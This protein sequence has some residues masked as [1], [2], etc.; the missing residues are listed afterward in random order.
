MKEIKEISVLKEKYGSEF[1]LSDEKNKEHNFH[2]LLELSV[3]N[4]HYAYFKQ[5]DE[6][7]EYIEVLKVIKGDNNELDLIHVEDDNEWEDAAELYDEWT[8]NFD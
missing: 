1:I 6:Q 2:L 5:D 7:E 3:E 4:N 8:Y